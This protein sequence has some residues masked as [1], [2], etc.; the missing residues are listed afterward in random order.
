[1]YLYA[2]GAPLPAAVR[3]RT[4]SNSTRR[5]SWRLSAGLERS[6]GAAMRKIGQLRKAGDTL[7]L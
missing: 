2:P 3:V 1:M 4:A 7:G 6:V 5:F